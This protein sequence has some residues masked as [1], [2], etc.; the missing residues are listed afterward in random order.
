LEKAET[1]QRLGKMPQARLGFDMQ[2]YNNR[3]QWTN[4][5]EELLKQYYCHP[6]CMSIEK[7]AGVLQRSVTAVKR[8]RDMLKLRRIGQKNRGLKQWLAEGG[9]F[10]I[11][12]GTFQERKEARDL[13][14]RIL[15]MT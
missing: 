8:K 13:E 7:I 4:V 1:L 9:R 2:D 10:E 14:K 5:E 3:R 15:E 12:S 6:F 11:P